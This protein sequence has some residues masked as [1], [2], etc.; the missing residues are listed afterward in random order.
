MRFEA[1]GGKIT[2]VEHGYKSY[3]FDYIG[4]WRGSKV[5]VE[6]KHGYESD[7]LERLKNKPTNIWTSQEKRMRF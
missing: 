4:E 5:F 1:Q 6:V 3:I 2:E 7:L